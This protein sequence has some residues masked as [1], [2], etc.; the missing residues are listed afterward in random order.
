MTKPTASTDPNDLRQ[1]ASQAIGIA[2]AVSTAALAVLAIIGAIL[3]YIASNYHDLAVFYIVIGIASLLMLAGVYLGIRGVAEITNNGYSGHWE[4]WT[5]SHL[6]DK[7]ALCAL[8]GFV[9]LGV[10]LPLGFTATRNSSALQK[11]SEPSSL[12]GILQSLAVLDGKLVITDTELARLA[13][14]GDPC[15]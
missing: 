8:C 5:K 14:C 15:R 4:P 13:A 10:A 9:A 12:T 2:G 1:A 11:I 3:T 7:Q 6:F